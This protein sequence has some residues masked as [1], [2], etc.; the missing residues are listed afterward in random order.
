M[1][2]PDPFAP[3]Y[4]LT[5]GNQLNDRIANPVWSTTS[6]ISA[7]P[8]GTMLNSASITD[9]I[10]NITTASAPGA[11][12]VLPQ[13]L[14]GTVL[15]VSNNSGNDVRVFAE[16]DSTIDGL[17]GVIGLI[18][19]KG[20]T[21]IFTAVATKEWTWLNTSANAGIT[22]V[23][24]IANLRAT[25]VDLYST[26]LVDG[27][28]TPGD[29]GGGYFY[30]VT[31][32]APG[33]YVDNGGT[34]I[35]PGDGSSAWLRASEWPLDVRWFG[36]KGDGSHDDSAAIQNAINAVGASG[37]SVYVPSECYCAVYSPLTIAT[38]N[39][40]LLFADHSAAIVAKAAMSVLLTVT[41][42][43][44]QL[45]NG[46]IVSGGVFAATGVY[47][48]GANAYG[49]TI[50]NCYF[51]SFTDAIHYDAVGDGGLFVRYCNMV[52]NTG[53]GIYISDGGTASNIIGNTINSTAT[54]SGIYITNSTHNGEG[55]NI[56]NNSIT[57]ANL[58]FY[59]KGGLFWNVCYNVFD[60][61]QP[62]G[63]AVYFD[64]GV[65]D[66]QMAYITFASNHVGTTS[67]SNGLIIHNNCTYFEIE[68]NIIDGTGTT[69][70]VGMNISG[71]AF[72][73]FTNNNIL[74]I[75]GTQISV[76]STA[77]FNNF[78]G[79]QCRG[80]GTAVVEDNTCQSIWMGNYIGS[81]T[82]STRSYYMWNWFQ[83]V[84]PTESNW[85]A[86]TPTVSSSTGTI[87]SYTSTGFFRRLGNTVY[88]TVNVSI[89]DNGT[90]NGTL[91]VTLPSNAQLSLNQ[92][93]TGATTAITPG[94]AY[95]VVNGNT[96]LTVLKYNG[97]YPV[98]TGETISLSGSYETR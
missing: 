3:G 43:G 53:K 84:L 58:A 59:A 37:G 9:T 98:A 67:S 26:M 18:L 46:T 66:H 48:T 69:G 2:T 4:R 41:G 88:V 63:A 52:S 35:V 29:G 96:N 49:F 62:S 90:G 16:G 95:G 68:N 8:G 44:V 82:F 42:D 56:Q 50:D 39:F 36:A 20:T 21:A 7:T 80:S 75:P 91:I 45:L 17:A 57:V 92:V 87:T 93:L 86:Y 13:A 14:L 65:S 1:T 33:T 61:Y 47:K 85:T 34:I 76:A 83:D 12:V 64:A 32:A 78:I 40:T 31:G 30:G 89:T 10:T 97:S 51:A 5:D 79:N 54:G 73:R 60:L 77:V 94:A 24:N 15:I 74:G 19:G 28:Y 23:E 72:C 27:Y 81:G 55:I 22:T 71:I 11:G 6:A 38:N 25:T 70:S